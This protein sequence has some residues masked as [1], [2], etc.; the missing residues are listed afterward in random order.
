[1]KVLVIGD[2]LDY[3]IQLSNSLSKT[4]TVMLTIIGKTFPAEYQEIIDKNVSLYLLLGKG[5]PI[6]FDLSTIKLVIEYIKKINEYRPDIIH[7]QLGY[8]LIY[9]LLLPLLLRYPVVSTF[10]DVKLHKGEESK[11]VNIIW[12]MLRKLS[13]RIF[14]HGKY[15]KKQLNQEYGISLDKIHAIPI[16]EHNVAPLKRYSVNNYA[17]DSNLILFF[18]RIQKYKGLDYLIRA[19]PLITSEYSNAKIVIAGAGEDFSKYDKMMINKKS[20]IVYNR[21]IS[22]EDAAHLFKTCAM[23]IL[24]YVEASKSGVIPVAYSFKKPV[25]VTDVGSLPEIVDDG[26]TGLIVKPKNIDELAAAIKT[27]LKDDKLR[28]TMGA[29]GYQKLHTDLSWDRISAK[30]LEVY[31]DLLAENR[32]VK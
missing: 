31:E 18:G 4:N 32:R 7:L 24:P 5:K 29:N 20:F 16:G 27:L 3:Q 12:H 13:K 2:F 17:E 21:R 30:T 25:I 23:V 10:H 22:D 26:V 1:M 15:L 8:S 9:I 19:E 14:V 6:Y 11:V 28:R